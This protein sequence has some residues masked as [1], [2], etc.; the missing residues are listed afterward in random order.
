[1]YPLHH[2]HAHISFLGNLPALIL[3]CNSSETKLF[4]NDGKEL[5]I[6]GSS[7]D[8]SLG[9]SMA[10]LNRKLGIN[11]QD[12]LVGKPIRQ[13]IPVP[14]INHKSFDFS[15]QGILSKV[16]YYSVHSPVVSKIDPVESSFSKKTKRD[17]ASL[18]STFQIVAIEHLVAQIRKAISWVRKEHPQVKTFVSTI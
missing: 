17:M 16:L 6:I 11:Y 18:G 7:V 4:L 1:M 5:K 15:F 2:T 8:L 3:F 13:L 14:M 12:M 10:I 9:E